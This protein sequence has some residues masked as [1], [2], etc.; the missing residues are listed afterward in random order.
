MEERRVAVPTRP[1]RRQALATLLVGVI[2]LASSLAGAAPKNPK[3]RAAFDEGIAAYQKAD[4]PA[5]AAAFGKAYGIEADVEALFAWA[6]SERQQDHCEKAIE[7]YGKLLESSLPDEN[8]Q[9]VS[10]KLAECKKLVAAKQPEPATPPKP[11]PT[12]PKPEPA[13]MPANPEGKS[14]FKDPI[15]GVLLGTGVVALG[16]GTY[17][18]VAAKGA[19]SD[20]KSATNYFDVERFNDDADSKGKL[21]VVATLAGGALIVAGVVRYATHRSKPRAVTGWITPEGGGI[22]AFG[23]F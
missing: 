20:A 12:P 2:V 13:P 21:G 19:D 4:W 22:A 8:K 7:L 11:E 17:F 5:A 6:Q 9:V 23:R 18:L 15:G 16:V 14:R 10:E 1:P 3:A